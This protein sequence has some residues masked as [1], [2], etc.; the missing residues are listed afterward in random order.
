MEMLGSFCGDKHVSLV[1][2]SLNLS[3]F[4]VALPFTS[5]MHDCIE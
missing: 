4:A 1:L 5:I 2:L 3:L